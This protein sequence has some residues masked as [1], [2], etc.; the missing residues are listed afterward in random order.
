VF[1]D[2]QPGFSPDGRTLSFIRRIGVGIS[3]VYLLPLSKDFH[4]V[5]DPRRLTFENHLALAP[6]WASDGQQIIYSSGPYLGP[7][8]FRVAASGSGKPQRLATV[9]E[10]ATEAAISHRA[11]RL[12]YTRLL[13]D[14]NIW[15]LGLADGSRKTV[16]ASTRIDGHAQFSPDGKKIA[17]SSNRD[18]DFEIWI[19]DSDGSNAQRLTSRG[20]YCASPHWS[21]DGQQIA[22][23]SGSSGTSWKVYLVSINGGKPKPLTNGLTTD[24]QPSWS[25]DGKWIYFTSN[26]SGE[27]Q[28]WKVPSR[29][30]DAMAVTHKGGYFALESQDGRWV[31]YSKRNEATSLWKVP[32]E[33]GEESQVLESVNPLAFAIV[34]NGIYFI[35]Q[36]PES[37]GPESAGANS[38]RFFDFATKESQTIFRSER[39]IEGYLSVS[40]DGQQILYSQSDLRGSDLMLVENFK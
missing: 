32:S 8:L 34:Q 18:G 33:G 26:R 17:F 30:G 19:C 6:V 2:S 11:Q 24:W 29:G 3:D 13:A 7:N 40:P 9:G 23:D 36:G 4:P 39:S 5:G 21:P 22:F 28:V 25:R 16:V 38:I 35:L 31:Y 10:D 27:D 15:G 1:V 14:V 20:V 12:V 37:P